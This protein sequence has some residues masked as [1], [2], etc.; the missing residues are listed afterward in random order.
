[1]EKNYIVTVNSPEEEGFEVGVNHTSDEINIAIKLNQSVPGKKTDMKV[2]ITP[3]DAKV[4]DLPERVISGTATEAFFKKFGIQKKGCF[5]ATPDSKGNWSIPASTFV[6]F[7]N[8]KS[9][10]TGLD[11]ITSMDLRNLRTDNVNN[12]SQMFVGCSSLTSLDVSGFNTSNVTNMGGMFLYCTKLTSLDLSGWDVSKVTD[13]SSMFFNCK[14]LTSLNLSGWHFDNFH[15]IRDMFRHCPHLITLDLSGWSWE[16]VI[17][18]S[19]MFHGC[20]SLKTIRMVGCDD[21]TITK[22]KKR[23]EKDGVKDVTIVTE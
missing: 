10:F 12:M 9:V 8:L 19:D 2:S 15:K 5:G 14:N 23:L 13:M 17:D 11:E 22:I 3:C 4:V 18:S 6:G 16:M 20:S 1:M 21:E 7:H